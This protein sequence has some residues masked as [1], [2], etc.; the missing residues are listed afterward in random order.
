MRRFTCVCLLLFIAPS[1]QV[2]S[3]PVP[4]SKDAKPAIINAGSEANIAGVLENIVWGARV[5]VRENKKVSELPIIKGQKDWEAWLKKNLRVERVAD[6]KL[7]RVSFR[8]GSREDQ[9][10]IINVVV[11][12]YLIND[13][14]RRR[15]TLKS[16]LEQSRVIVA[17]LAARGKFTAKEVAEAEK[18]IKKAEERIRALPSLVEHAKVR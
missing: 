7:V 3:A 2:T 4:E 17:Q 12:Y 18:S 10:A 11:D 13:I 8:D 5:G 16:D 15:A 6:T 14:G 9:A 1:A